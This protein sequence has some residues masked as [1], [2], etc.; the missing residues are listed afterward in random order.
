M[1]YHRKRFLASRR[2]WMPGGGIKSATVQVQVNIHRRGLCVRALLTRELRPGASD[3]P[4]DNDPSQQQ[5]S[6]TQPDIDILLTCSNPTQ[7]DAI[8]RNQHPW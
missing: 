5:T 8:G 2:P 3:K 7:P 1:P 6:A 4:S